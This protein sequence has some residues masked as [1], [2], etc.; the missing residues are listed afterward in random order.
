[1]QLHRK[2]E[3]KRVAKFISQMTK[4][5]GIAQLKIISIYPDKIKVNF[6]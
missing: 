5:I 1:M 6:F 2:V 3:S 4:K